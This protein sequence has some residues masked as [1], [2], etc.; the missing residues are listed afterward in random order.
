MPEYVTYDNANGRIIRKY[1]SVS[2]DT[3]FGTPYVIQ[4][5]R[6]VYYTITKCSKVDNGV[7]VEMTQVEKDAL[8]AEEEQARIDAENA[9]I[10]NLIEKFQDSNLQGIVIDRADT[11]IDNIGSLADA[12]VFL[13]KLCRFIIKY[14]AS[15]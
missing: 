14:V 3:D 1:F 11:A 4:I 12:K 13:K 2:E 9:R 8:L 6:S 5:P 7:V 10:F 15:Q